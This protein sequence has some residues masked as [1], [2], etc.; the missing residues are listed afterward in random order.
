MGNLGKFK[1][2]LKQSNQPLQEKPKLGE[3]M[4]NLANEDTKAQAMIQEFL[5]RLS[6]TGWFD[7]FPEPARTE[8]Q[9]ST[10]VIYLNN[11]SSK[12]LV[13][14]PGVYLDPDC[15]EK[16]IHKKII[17]D[18]ANNSLGLFKPQ[19]VEETWED[20]KEDFLIKV[21][22][23]TQNKQYTKQWP[24]KSMWVEPDFDDLIKEAVEG[25][26][27]NLTVAK[28]IFDENYIGYIICNKQALPK[29]LE[30]GLFVLENYLGHPHSTTDSAIDNLL[31]IFK[32]KN[33][34]LR[35]YAAT[36]LECLYQKYSPPSEDIYILEQLTKDKDPLIRNAAAYILEEYDY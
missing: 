10:K 12:P 36:L 3:T 32:D 16:G 4:E 8:I 35:L 31:T 17:E 15:V 20:T 1:K 18:F 5:T 27:T 2:K 34:T 29:T 7:E 14:I 11:K 9:Q 22:I 24:R 13:I 25:T 33:S 30:A 23:T 19:S 6:Q 26:H 28:I 21:T